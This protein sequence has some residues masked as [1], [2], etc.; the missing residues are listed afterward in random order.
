M[1]NPIFH[2]DSQYN[3]NITDTEMNRVLSKAKNKKAVGIDNIPNEIWKSSNNLKSILQEFFQFCFD[4]GTIPEIWTN[5]EIVPI[6]KSSNL[7]PRQPLNYRGL[8]LLCTSAKLYSSFLNARL[9]NYLEDNDKLTDEQNGFRAKRS[10]LDHVFALTTIVRNRLEKKLDTY[11]AFIDLQKAFDHIHRKLLLFK[12]LNMAVNGKLYFAIKS[13]LMNSK[14]CVR[15]N[16]CNT[17]YFEV[18]NGV[19][20]GDPI[21]TTLFAIFINDL[22]YDINSLEKGI[23]IDGRIVTCLSYADDF[24]LICEN[25]QALECV[26]ECMY[27]WC[28]KWRVT[29]NV[30][31]SNVIHFRKSRIRRSETQFKLGNEILEY[32]DSY[33]YLGVT[34]DEH[35][36]YN[37][38]ILQL[39]NSGNRA[40]GSVISTY[41]NNKSM[42]HRTYEKL[43]TSCI[44]PILDYCAAIWQ[45]AD[46]SK[47]DQIQ[48]KAIRIYL[49]VN[50]FAP[51][52]G[53][54]GE[55]GW[56]PGSIRRKLEICRLWNRLIKMEDTRLTKH[57]F[58]YDYR[59]NVRNTW[60]Y[61]ALQIFTEID[62][63]HV[64]DSQQLCN[65]DEIC[66]KLVAKYVSDWQN[67]IKAKPKLRFYR[68]FKNEPATEL[69]VKSN[70][71]T[72]ERSCLAQLRL[73]ILP[74][75]VETGRYNSVPYENRKCK[76]CNLD[77][78]G[79]E[80]HLLFRCT[81][82]NDARNV[83]LN[84][85]DI[86]LETY[87]SDKSELLKEVFTFPRQT[88]KYICKC[89]DIRRNTLYV[90][91]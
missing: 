32:V 21:S 26:L 38:V 12:I 42:G 47:I 88:A 68:Y 2:S 73:G 89:M 85:I 56:I 28:K 17:E 57:V 35:M 81:N 86:N 34:L 66:D 63:K 24:A 13:L 6:P 62:M 59:S 3:R 53:L 83:W 40:L 31:K 51:L 71:S 37:D 30:K 77:E 8:S 46:C 90:Q 65:I 22:V 39:A 54:N 15:V 44:A 74:I 29:V 70:L 25:E 79:D 45:H 18:G 52:L 82:F 7:D 78:I 87:G 72:Y 55:C 76:L 23:C 67:Q 41:K 5:A 84:Q 33:K 16:E 36:K 61:N 9:L 10:C 69:Y 49:G 20:Q 50:R 19:R 11:V 48:S 14:S 64:Y 80:L 27:G 4:L 43:F 75:E 60:C 1:T 91:R 58:I